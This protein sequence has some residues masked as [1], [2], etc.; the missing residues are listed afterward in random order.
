[1]IILFVSIKSVYLK[2]II[3][4]DYVK[5]AERNRIQLRSEDAS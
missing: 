4:R 2:S 3:Y 1:M 5:V